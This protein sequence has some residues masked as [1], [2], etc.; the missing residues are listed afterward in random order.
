MTTRQGEGEKKPGVQVCS[1]CSVCCFRDADV[2]IGNAARATPPEYRAV[3][4]R[5]MLSG[6]ASHARC[7]VP[8]HPWLGFFHLSLSL[9]PNRFLFFVFKERHERK[10]KIQANTPTPVSS[11]Y[12]KQAR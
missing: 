12:V 3:N 4:V 6:L 2:S 7:L 5:K 9:F 1:C 11:A 8:L 10:K